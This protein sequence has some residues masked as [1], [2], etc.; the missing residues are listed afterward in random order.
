MLK[1]EAD[2]K[3][4]LELLKAVELFRDVPEA[5]LRVLAENSARR[6]YPAN[7]V[8]FHQGDPGDAMYLVVSGSL[9]VEQAYENNSGWGEPRGRGQ[10]IGEMALLDG[11]KRMATVRVL[12]DA[13]LLTIH[14]YVFQS[15][16]HD[17][18][19]F[20]SAILVCLAR[21]LRAAWGR[22][23]SLQQ[24]ELNLRIQG[25]LIELAE[26]QLQE[27]PLEPLCLQLKQAE[28][29]IMTGANP[30]E[31]SK[32]IKPLKDSGIIEIRRGKILIHDF[33]ALRKWQ[34]K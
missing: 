22:I 27:K 28:L 23:H 25:R 19:D 11:E 26:K 17:S 13:Q 6:N 7:T 2:A 8:L 10:I 5:A 34:W 3:K 20:A 31:V 14:R 9:L 4:R 29:A 12:E 1:E 16:M 33:D 18:P 30:Q 21:R 24:E 32:M 15:V